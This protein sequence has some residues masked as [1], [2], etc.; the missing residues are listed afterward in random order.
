[1]E[2][3]QEKRK[4]RKRNRGTSGDPRG[5]EESAEKIGCTEE[6]L[7]TSESDKSPQQWRAAFTP[8]Q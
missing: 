3:M 6:K 7:N 5:E 8:N 1:M 4:R 2:A